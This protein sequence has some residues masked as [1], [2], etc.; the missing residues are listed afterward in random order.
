MKLLR[1]GICLMAL[2]MLASSASSAQTQQ[3]LNDILTLALRNSA[4]VR[5]AQADVDKAN[6]QLAQVHNAYIPNFSVASGLGQA[7]GFS[8]NQSPIFS[9]TSQSL[10]F[11]FTH[12]EEQAAARRGLEAAKYSLKDARE[13]VIFEAATS[14]SRLQSFS[15]ELA[16]LDLAN[17]YA[18]QYVEIIRQRAEAGLSTRN[19]WTQAQLTAAN[20]R[21]QHV[22]LENEEATELLHLANVVHLPVSDLH[23]AGDAFPDI[24]HP[25]TRYSPPGVQATEALAES[26]KSLALADERAIY[27]PEFFLSQQYSRYADYNNLSSY[28][29]NFQVNGYGLGVEIS[30]PIFDAVKRAKGRESSADALHARIEAEM[31]LTLSEEHSATLERSLKEL[32]AAVEVANLK[33][34]L[35]KDQLDASIALVEV[36]NGQPNTPQATPGLV[37][38]VHIQERQRLLESLE[39]GFDLVKLKLSLLRATGNLEDWAAHLSR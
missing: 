36:G 17:G 31:A 2:S 32:E 9:A 27:R 3:S 23:L 25:Q 20:L 29:T 12:Q 11:S 1:S 24:P 37:M 13:E 30:I 22:H 21:L 16:A 5:L 34:E 15:A 7:F 26:K 8:P 14:Y 28:Y 38:Q 35:A 4:T 19:E 6:A 10:V 33:Q 39:A 18:E